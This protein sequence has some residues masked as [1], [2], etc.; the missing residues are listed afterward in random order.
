[1]LD[2]TLLHDWY[3]QFEEGYK[4]TIIRGELYPDSSKSRYENTDANTNFRASL[5]AGIRKG[6]YI[7]AS[8]NNMIYLLDWEVHLETNNAPSRALR[9]NFYLTIQRYTDPTIDERGYEIEDSGGYKTIV[10]AIPCNAYRYDG[11][12]E[13]SASSSTPGITPNAYT[14]LNV[15]Y[16][17][18]TKLIH[19]DDRF[20]WG[21]DT[22][23]I[24]D[25]SR[26]GLSIDSTSGCLTLRCRRD[27]GGLNYA[28]R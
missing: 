9:C 7:I 12:P 14:I 16:N 19:V 25:V 27:T 24:V 4:P 28:L 26:V 15:Q 13:F 22:Y 1:M 10:D 21:D 3:E 5:T 23:E 17:E 8:N 2:F 6:D 11:R 18:Q 20:I